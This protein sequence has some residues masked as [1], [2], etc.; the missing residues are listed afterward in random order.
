MKFLDFSL[1]LT[2]YTSRFAHALCFGF[3]A[4]TF[5]GNFLQLKRICQNLVNLQS[6]PLLCTSV[7][8]AR[9]FTDIQRECRSG[10]EMES[11]P[12]TVPCPLKIKH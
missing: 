12:Y 9:Q 6:K 7:L 10:T 1:F 3:Q 11:S 8:Q 4:H 5:Q 2:R